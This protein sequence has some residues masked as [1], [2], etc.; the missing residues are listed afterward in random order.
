MDE[1]ERG[2]SSGLEISYNLM[3]KEAGYV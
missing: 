2:N 3:D 1:L